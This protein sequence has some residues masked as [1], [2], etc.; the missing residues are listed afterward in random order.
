MTCALSYNCRQTLV[1]YNVTASKSGLIKAET[2]YMHYST[3]V[4]K[5]NEMLKDATGIDKIT[6][7]LSTLLAKRKY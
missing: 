7:K 6:A 4:F 3:N 1:K 5:Y 2:P